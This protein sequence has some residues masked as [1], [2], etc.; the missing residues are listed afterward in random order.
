MDVL[1]ILQKTLKNSAVA[2]ILIDLSKEFDTVGRFLL[3][4]IRYW[5]E[6]HGP[7]LILS[8][9]GA[10]ITTPALNIMETSVNLYAIM[11]YFEEAR[12][13]QRL[14]HVL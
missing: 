9:M 2:L 12:L 6:C 4:D 10:E 1:S 11:V 13:S 14:Y 8:E 3:W 7:V 5:E